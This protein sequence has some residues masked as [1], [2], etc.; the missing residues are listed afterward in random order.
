MWQW[1]ERKL[2]PDSEIDEELEYHLAMLAAEQRDRGDSSGA[3]QA[4]AKRKTGNIT[5]IKEGTRAAWRTPW[6]E[7]AQ[8]D[9]HFTARMFAR[10]PF[11]YSLVIG[12]LA[13]GIT[14]SVSLFSLIDGV[15]LRPLPYRDP[16][17]L[18]ALTSYAPKAALRIQRLRLLSRLSI[19]FPQSL[20][21]FRNRR[22]LSHR[23][24]ASHAIGQ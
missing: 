12:I 14:A 6:L 24:V 2:P 4:F 3:A 22:H 11:F 17:R 10:S 5:L 20:L 19:H 18:V 1:L 9:L 7:E 15:L 21:L 23:L 8:R 13:L 16:S